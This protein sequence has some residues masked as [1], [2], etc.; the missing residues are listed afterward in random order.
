MEASWCFLAGIMVTIIRPKGLGSGWI[1]KP[2]VETQPL[3]PQ[4]RLG[5]WVATQK[6]RTVP[7]IVS[8]LIQLA[9]K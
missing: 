9:L 7:P 1:I 2:E 6:K 4:E 8:V 3:N 5:S